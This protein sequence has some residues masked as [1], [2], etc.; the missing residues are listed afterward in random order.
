MEFSPRGGALNRCSPDYNTTNLNYKRTFNY[1]SEA[2]CT[3]LDGNLVSGL[4]RIHNRP[5]SSSEAM[6]LSSASE[7]AVSTNHVAEFSQALL[8]SSPTRLPSAHCYL[9]LYF[10]RMTIK[11]KGLGACLH[12]ARRR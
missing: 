5:G 7:F 9:G 1:S 3:P 4:F 8:V 2:V 6:L 12:T 10:D 11:W